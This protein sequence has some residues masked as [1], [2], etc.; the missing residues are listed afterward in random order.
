V[1]EQR[2][3]D[4]QRHRVIDHQ[5]ARITV[6]QRCVQCSSASCP[7]PAGGSPVTTMTLAGWKQLAR[8]RGSYFAPLQLLLIR[9]EAIPGTDCVFANGLV[10]REVSGGPRYEPHRRTRFENWQTGTQRRAAYD[11]DSLA[12]SLANSIVG[13]FSRS[14]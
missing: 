6:P 3:R 11:D 5:R 9:V 8:R 4:W 1:S 10:A 12:R 13:F 2:L 14:I 7:R